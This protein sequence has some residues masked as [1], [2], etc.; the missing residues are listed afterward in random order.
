[1]LDS[2]VKLVEAVWVSSPESV[3]QDVRLSPPQTATLR[4]VG[5][6]SHLDRAVESGAQSEHA[7][8]A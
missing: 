3:K 4:S 7:Q 8:R 5:L 2:T 6:V 1:M